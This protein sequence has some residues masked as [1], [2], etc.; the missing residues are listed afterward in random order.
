MGTSELQIPLLPLCFMVLMHEL[1]VVKNGEIQ[2]K[3]LLEE[4]DNVMED[5]ANQLPCH[6]DTE[7]SGKDYF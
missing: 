3:P 6:L 4:T 2:G 7:L 5:G 1:K